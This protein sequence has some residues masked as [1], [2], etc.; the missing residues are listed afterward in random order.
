M[1]YS[2]YNAIVHPLRAKVTHTKRRAVIVITIIWMLSAVVAFPQILVQSLITNDD[3]VRCEEDWSN[4]VA[5]PGASKKA[6]VVCLFVLFFAVPVSIIT[7]AYI[8]IIKRLTTTDGILAETVQI[9]HD[10][11]SEGD[12]SIDPKSVPISRN[13]RKTTFMML[14]V[15]VAFLVC[16]LPLNTLLLVFTFLKKGSYDINAFV[17]AF[18][19]LV[20]L[21]VCSAACNPIIYNFF[22]VKFRRAFVDVFRSRCGTKETEE[23]SRYYSSFRTKATSL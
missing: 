13:N 18:S 4:L 19:V 21:S 10:T 11:S 16:M 2:R 22:S 6:H 15:I 23:K 14:T 7:V 3:V 20:V 1:I 12:Q 9:S 5:N 8:T 17:D